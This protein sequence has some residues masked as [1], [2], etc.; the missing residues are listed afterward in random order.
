M[1]L[2]CL[3]R[4]KWCTVLGFFGVC[5][6]SGIGLVLGGPG[7]GKVFQ[8]DSR[9]AAVEVTSS[10]LAV[11]ADD[12]NKMEGPELDLGSG[13]GSAGA[14][15]GAEANEIPG[16]ANPARQEAKS[17]PSEGSAA[18]KQNMSPPSGAE[19]EGPSAEPKAP[20]PKESAESVSPKKDRE[21][22][23][24]PQKGNAPKIDPSAVGHPLASGIV[25]LLA[26][27]TVGQMH[28][29]GVDSRFQ[30]FLSY[31]A[32]R[33]AATRGV[34]TGNEINGLA[35]LSWFD[36][37]LREPLRVPQ[38]AEEF[39][40][41]LHAGALSDRA[42]GLRFLLRT[43]RARMDVPPSTIELDEHWNDPV[44]F[45]QRALVQAYNLYAQTVKP[46][47]QAEFTELARR[48]NYVMTTNTVVGHTVNDRGSARRLVQLLE[49]MDRAAQWDMAE[50]LAGLNDR[51]FL[52]SLRQALGGS[53]GHG[54]QTAV[55]G[56]SGTVVRKIET[57]VGTIVVGGTGANEYRLEEM[58]GV[59]AIV[60]LG[61][62]DVYWE[63]T[64]SVERPL[65][66]IIDY[67][68]ND[69]YQGKLPGIQ[70]AAILGGSL[71][72][73]LAGN[74][75]YWAQD[76]AQGST[77]G[78]VGILVDWA[79]NDQYLGL[80]R[81]QGQAIGGVGVLIDREGQ[82]DYHAAMWAQGFG[83]PL[84]F[85]LIDD[86][87]GDDHYYVGGR[88]YDSYPETPGYEGWGQ[89]VGSGIRGAAN[90]GI[91]VLLEGAGDD[92][93]EFDYFSQGGGYW[94]AIG[95]AR[96]FAGNDRRL[97]ATLKAYDGSARTQQRF[98]RFGNGWGCH[99]GVGALID[100]KGD[101]EYHGSIMGTGFGWD[102][103]V[104][105]LLELGGDDHY[106]ARV[107]GVQ[108]Q[109]AQAS[110]GVL[111]DFEGAD[112][113]AGTSQGYASS[114]IT[115]HPYPTCGG[116][117]S[118]VVDYGGMDRYGSGAKN[119][120][121]TRRGTGGFIVDRPKEEEI[122]AAQAESSDS[123]DTLSAGNSR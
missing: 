23:P 52:E 75:I 45:L 66:L 90:G 84:G 109:G 81:V 34:Y 42:A 29:T 74:D 67:S 113:Y 76:V 96:D 18:D 65:L 11:F 87:A 47:S 25:K 9:A 43:A 19:T 99:M 14:P 115:Y 6:M 35:R 85:G 98:Q 40:R 62:D 24:S 100:D 119:N 10:D 22:E 104:G 92:T 108:G 32:S 78:G 55:P 30:Q 110:L 112:E 68:G 63:G 105:Y 106:L 51:L 79:G 91:G 61:G 107:G 114:A 103:S 64:V 49:K 111:Y 89:G 60:D 57:S 26:P 20:R 102:L 36:H 58:K 72:I 41:Y 16:S 4:V 38:E 56:V 44:E 53:A 50:V 93:Y 12:P 116:N 54:T 1:K 3:D 121:I 27:E 15:P 39:T 48:I 82:D 37:L 28:S 120:A 69:R 123:R 86:L 117:F 71:L 101:D 95:F 7:D 31:T 5:G 118:F 73:D 2:K 21:G 94:L 83:G 8:P 97:G 80:R 13:S 77:L 59:V 33:L 70:G 17:E 122:Q 88:W 46:L